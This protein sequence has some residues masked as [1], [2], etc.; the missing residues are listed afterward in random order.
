[1]SV[2]YD[3]KDEGKLQKANKDWYELYF[4]LHKFFPLKFSTQFSIQNHA[5]F[6]DDKKIYEKF[7]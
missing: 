7:K 4:A 5:F 3:K 6:F 1:M 2:E